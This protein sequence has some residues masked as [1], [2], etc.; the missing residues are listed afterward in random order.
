MC[1]C[2][3]ALLEKFTHFPSTP[4]RGCG[5][6]PGTKVGAAVGSSVGARLG[7]PVGKSVADE[8]ISTESQ[9]ALP[10]QLWS[11]SAPTYTYNGGPGVPMVSARLKFPH[12]PAVSPKNTVES[13][14]LISM[15]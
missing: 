5:A 8:H 14:T 13:S 3:R 7:A 1:F 12:A 6:P 15:S 9:M 11:Q 10:S 4:S 2:D